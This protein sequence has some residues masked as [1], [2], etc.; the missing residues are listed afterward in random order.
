[1]TTPLSPHESSAHRIA[2]AAHTG[3]VDRAGNPYFGHIERVAQAV[4]AAGGSET[5]VV[6][7]YLHD[8]I[9][10]TDTTSADLLDAGVSTDALALIETLTRHDEVAYEDYL[11]RIRSS[12]DASLV[13]QCDMADNMDPARTALLDDETRE[14]LRRKYEKAVAFLTTTA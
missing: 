14:R 5:Q 11:Q 8:V 1:M 4:K 3:Q 13:K 2:E 7:A 10:D 12:P 6:A 9:E